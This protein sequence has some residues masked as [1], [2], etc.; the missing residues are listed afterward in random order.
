[1]LTRILSGL[2]G[3]SL[4]VG[5]LL[6]NPLAPWLVNALIALVCMLAISEV[7]TAMGIFKMYAVTIPSLVFVAIQPIVGDGMPWQISWYLYTIFIFCVMIFMNQV[8]TFKDIAVIYSMSLLITMSLS[9]IVTLRDQGD[10]A[11]QYF[12][13][14][15]LVVSLAL[16]WMADTGAYFFG[17]FFGK[18]KMCPNVSPKKTWEGAAGGLL[19]CVV[20][21]VL[22]NLIFDYWV[23]A[24]EVKVHYWNMLLLAVVGTVLSVLGDLCFSLI[25]RGCHI[26]DF[27]N[28]IPGHGGILD[29]FDSVIYTAPFLFLFTQ[30]LPLVSF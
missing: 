2:V 12:G 17:S 14:Y 10:A 1:M 9:K 29:R 21:M 23:F 8:L 7:F 28:A 11:G 4:I 13:I 27:G 5:I 30:Y 20:S 15:Y 6:L 18:H 19:I 16:P 3:A 25:K 22:V 24:P 26:K